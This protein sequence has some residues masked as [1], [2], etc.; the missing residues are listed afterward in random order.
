MKYDDS[1]TGG[2][3]Y[4]EK[5]ALVAKGLM[6]PKEIGMA[7][8][9]DAI[10]EITGLKKPDAQPWLS[11]FITF[12]ASVVPLE[13]RAQWARQEEK[14]I[15]ADSVGWKE[16][17]MDKHRNEHRIQAILRSG[18][19]KAM[20]DQTFTDP[21]YGFAELLRQASDMLTQKYE[22][23]KQ[24]NPEKPVKT[25]EEINTEHRVRVATGK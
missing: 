17:W 18:N 13:V 8:A 21:I 22:E 6:E 14:V 12:E 25:R 24:T 10:Y 9:D 4:S 1:Q 3:S 11:D 20:L 15:P 7:S 19:I 2:Y 16:A 23:I 5:L